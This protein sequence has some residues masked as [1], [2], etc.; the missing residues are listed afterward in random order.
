MVDDFSRNA[1][2]VRGFPH[3]NVSV[4]AEEV[5]E[6]AFLLGGKRG[7]NAHHF[8]LGGN[9][10]HGVFAALDFTLVSVLEGGADGDDP[11]G[12]RHL[13]LKVCIIGYSHELR[14][15]WSSQNGVESPR[16]PHYVEGEGLS[17][18]IGPIPESDG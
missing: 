16:E 18:V 13:Q 14:V 3:K 17:P 4:G 12:A 9:D 8:A 10:S 11:M 5:N 1:W 2:H 7:A 15:A 6:R